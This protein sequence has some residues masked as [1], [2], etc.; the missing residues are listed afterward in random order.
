M[1]KFIKFGV[2]IA[3]LLLGGCMNA[4]EEH[5]E[6]ISEIVETFDRPESGI[7]S[8][9]RGDGTDTAIDV[10]SV[11]KKYIAIGTDRSEVVKILKY[12]K[13]GYGFY[14]YDYEYSKKNKL[15]T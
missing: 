2:C 11:V 15:K 5:G 8:Y 6:I 4:S 10:S 13:E 1:K 7:V 14:T 9:N 12:K 3:F